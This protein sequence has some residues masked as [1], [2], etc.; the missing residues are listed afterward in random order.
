MNPDPQPASRLSRG[1]RWQSLLF[2]AI[3][4]LAAGFVIYIRPLIFSGLKWRPCVFYQVTG[5]PCP[6]CGG[7][8]ATHALLRG[9]FP[10]ALYYNAVAFPVAA[11][12]ALALGAWLFEAATGTAVY[13]RLARFP[14]WRAV[15]A[16]VAGLLI[17]WWGWHIADA[18]STPKPELIC[19]SNPICRYLIAHSGHAWPDPMP[20]P[21]R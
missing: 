7:T 10:L 21:P 15:L 8:R 3:G 5:L 9:D 12:A 18:I 11:V 13:G 17:A 14:H 6:F 2:F 20:S 16:M 1:Q 4:T 19:P